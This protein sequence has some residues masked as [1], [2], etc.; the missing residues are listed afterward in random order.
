MN[1]IPAVCLALTLAAPGSK[2]PPK[3]DP[4]TIVGEWTIVRVSAGEGVAP[5]PPPAAT[6]TFTADGKFEYRTSKGVAYRSGTYT[7]DPKKNP[8]EIDLTG[9]AVQGVVRP[10]IF[11]LDGDTL[12]IGLGEADTRP[13]SFGGSPGAAMYMY[14][15][16]RVKKD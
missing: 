16:K 1:A 11:K 8:A 14:E 9:E 15:Y 13:T 2:D 3:K 5:V 7:V 4:P 10:G 12:T 6:T